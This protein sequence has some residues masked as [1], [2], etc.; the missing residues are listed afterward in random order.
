MARLCR[1][2]ESLNASL[3]NTCKCVEV[4]RADI[5]PPVDRHKVA[6]HFTP[7]VKYIYLTWNFHPVVIEWMETWK[8]WRIKS[9]EDHYCTIVIL[10]R[11]SHCVCIRTTCVLSHKRKIGPYLSPI[12]VPHVPHG[13]AT[14]DNEPAITSFTAIS[15]STISTQWKMNSAQRITKSTV[16]TIICCCGFSV[17]LCGV[18]CVQRHTDK[19]YPEW[20]ESTLLIVKDK[21]DGIRL[22]WL[23]IVYVT[24]V[25]SDS[26]VIVCPFC[27][28]M[29][30]VEALFPF[31]CET[32][33][34]WVGL[35]EQIQAWFLQFSRYGRCAFGRFRLA[36]LCTWCWYCSCLK[37][38]VTLYNKHLNLDELSNWVCGACIHFQNGR[39]GRRV[40]Y[41]MV[42]MPDAIG[43]FIHVLCPC[44]Y[45]CDGMVSIHD[46]QCT[47]E[48]QR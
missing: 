42:S 9:S 36:E 15:C 12:H 37:F 5:R 46:V 28:S 18:H 26:R 30:I 43:K 16:S 10:H 47:Q 33:F 21:K 2:I 14:K 44:E 38:W 20:I 27:W 19:V 40:I 11:L 17:M 22:F 39:I 24:F 34:A 31:T 13:L 45:I 7:T 25:S 29:E 41:T 4:K 23:T 32:E 48:Y 8:L 35:D 3:N 6:M 1:C